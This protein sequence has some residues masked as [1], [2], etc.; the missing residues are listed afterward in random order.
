MTK[1]KTEELAGPPE[2]KR[3]RPTRTP[4]PRSLSRPTFVRIRFTTKTR[5]KAELASSELI[6]IPDVGY[7]NKIADS[8]EY[9]YDVV[10][11]ICEVADDKIKLYIQPDGELR[12]ED[13]EGWVAVDRQQAI[14]GGTYLCSIP[15]GRTT[16]T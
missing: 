7:L 15:E 3:Q 12:E 16:I 13:A 10:R 9:L 11:R 1:R 14:E 5:Q 4:K 6:C 2:E 8:C